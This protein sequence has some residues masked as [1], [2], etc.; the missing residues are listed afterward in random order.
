M[1][2]PQADIEGQSVP[3]RDRV[4]R[5]RGGRDGLTA[6]GGGAGRDRL[7]RLPV[8]VD[9]PHAGRDDRRVAMLAPFDGSAEFPLMVGAEQSR[10][11]VTERRLGRRAIVIPLP[12]GLRSS[13]R[14]IRHAIEMARRRQIA[15][16]RR[17]LLV[18]DE[19]SHTHIPNRIR[20]Q[21]AGEMAE[22]HRRH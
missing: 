4:V 5:K 1:V 12:E 19:S 7:K 13:G 6:V 22:R 17:A 14:D 2:E 9:E 20:R 11:I 3:S 21:R 8:V 16:A 15:G 10:L 18:D